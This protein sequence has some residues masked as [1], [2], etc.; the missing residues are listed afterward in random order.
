MRG[1]HIG[2]VAGIPVQLNWTFLVVLPVFAFLIGTDITM[3]TNLLEETLGRD[4]AAST[5]EGPYRPWLLGLAAAV[6]LFGGVLLHEFGHSLVALRF[7]C[8]IESITL[9]LL[10]GLASFGEMP[11]NWRQEFW[12][13]VAGPAVS[14]GVGLAF[15]AA[16]LAVPGGAS[17]LLFLFGYL[18]VVNVALA[19]FNM[20]PAFP[21]DGGRVLRA[22]L[23]RNRTHVRA[24]RLAAGT[25]KVFAVG[26]AIVGV[27]AN[28]FLV[29]LAVFVYIAAAGEARQTMFKA[30]FDDVTVGQ[31]MTSRDALETVRPD[32]PVASLIQRMFADSHTGYPV[33]G[34]A[35]Y[36]G[37]VTLDAATSVPEVEREAY[38]VEDVMEQDVTTVRPTTGAMTALEAIQQ[39][40]TGRLL[41]VDGGRLVGLI[42]RTDIMRGF[43]IIQSGG[44]P[45]SP[46]ES[47]RGGTA[48]EFTS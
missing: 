21:M 38:R 20:L 27:F 3:L 45:Q 29:V 44:Q 41:V 13:A 12:I 22:L 33:V 43:N 6:G 14:V 4:I 16:F 35:G 28:L 34:E 11:E 5:L 7:G 39:D 48:G 26:F 17:E 40:D 10:G 24:T 2:T 37:I 36:V 30:A 15:F 18:A 32:D 9:W 23:S 46:E 1:L 19:A 42:S 8:A 31:L 25:G 47:R